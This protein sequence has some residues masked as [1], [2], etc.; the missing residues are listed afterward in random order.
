MVIVLLLV[1]FVPPLAMT[2]PS[3]ARF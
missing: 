3:W 2:I 1:T